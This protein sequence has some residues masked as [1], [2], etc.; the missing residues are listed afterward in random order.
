M[1][2]YQYESTFDTTQTTQVVKEEG[3]ESSSSQ[4]RGLV[5][6]PPGAVSSGSNRASTGDL[7]AFVSH[8]F[9]PAVFLNHSQSN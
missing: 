9:L 1:S 4:T 6:T 5:L 2:E 3:E 8:V 7:A